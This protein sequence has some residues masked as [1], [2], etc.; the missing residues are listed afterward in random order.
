MFLLSGL[1]LYLFTRLFVKSLTSPVSKKSSLN[2]VF[3]RTE[4]SKVTFFFGFGLGD[5]ANIRTL[6]IMPQVVEGSS[7]VVKRRRIHS[8]DLDIGNDVV[9]IFFIAIIGLMSLD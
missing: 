2:G 1:T 7:R 9:R 6:P 4:G 3:K 5:V 8:N